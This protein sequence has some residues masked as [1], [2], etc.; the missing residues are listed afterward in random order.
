MHLRPQ[1][2]RFLSIL[3]RGSFAVDILFTFGPIFVGTLSLVLVLL[4]W[5][6]NNPDGEERAACFILTVS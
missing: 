6:C 2:L 5:F 4:S 1:W 3:R